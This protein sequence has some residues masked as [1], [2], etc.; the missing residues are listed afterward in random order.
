MNTQDLITKLSQDT[1]QKSALRQ[2]F[3]FAVQ[4][5]IV[6]TVYGLGT[7]FFLGLRPDVFIQLNRLAFSTEIALLTMLV[8]SSSVAAVMAMYPDAL[9]KVYALKIPYVVFA[10][11]AGFVVFQLAFM[12]Q[13]E[14]AVLPPLSPHG[15][16]CALCIG[17]VALIPAALLFFLLRKGASV[18]PLK[19]GSFAVLAAAGVGCLTLRLAESNDSLVHLASWHYLPTLIFAIIGAAVGK[20][21]LKW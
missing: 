9:Q 13:D 8:F 10:L 18:T 2:P 15:M 17:A 3:W 21:L 12:P 14:R 19:A 20:W 7:Q 6:L 5:I 16:E 11:L 4:L 1:P